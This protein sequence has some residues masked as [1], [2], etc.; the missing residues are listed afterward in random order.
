[1]IL[2]ELARYAASTPYGLLIGILALRQVADFVERIGFVLR[3][4]PPADA[5]LNTADPTRHRIQGVTDYD[6]VAKRLLRVLAAWIYCICRPIVRSCS[7][8]R[9]LLQDTV[10]VG[11]LD[12][13]L[14]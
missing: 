11:I 8:V 14:I 4:S 5:G 10:L 13:Q 1:M 7:H 3:G 9:D 6:R 2:K 12:F